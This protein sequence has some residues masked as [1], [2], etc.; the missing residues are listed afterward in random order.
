MLLSRT[1]TIQRNFSIIQVKRTKHNPTN[2]Y[3]TDQETKRKG[4]KKKFAW[5]KRW[6]RDFIIHW[7]LDPMRTYI[8]K[9]QK[10]A[11]QSPRNLTKFGNYKREFTL[12]NREEKT[13]QFFIHRKFWQNIANQETNPY[14]EPFSWTKWNEQ[15][16]KGAPFNT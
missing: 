16:I 10:Q 9:F 7:A 14:E 2:I 12:L 11:F 5:T 3:N 1:P 8:L 6:S 4:R 15:S 13:S